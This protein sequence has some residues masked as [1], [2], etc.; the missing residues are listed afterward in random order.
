MKKYILLFIAAAL[1]TGLLAGYVLFRRMLI[2]AP[3]SHRLGQ[4]LHSSAEHPNWLVKAGSRCGTA[5]FQFPT[6]GYIGFLWDDSWQPGQRHQGID[7]FSPE[8]TPVKTPVYAVSDGYLTRQPDW[9]SSVILRIPDDP[10]QPGRQLWTYYT[11]MA[12]PEG[13][14][15]I[16]KDFPPGTA[17]IFVKAGTLLGYQGNFSGDPKN[18]TGLHLHFSIVLDDGT[19]KYRNELKIENTLDPSPYL[20]LNLNAGKTGGEVV[21]C[22]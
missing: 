14:S 6:D 2:T 21:T 8:R 3:R 5:P 19:G 4:W 1:V 22:P 17:D 18:P 11:H 10:L 12:D 9:K 7:I 16:S 13:N 15:F 20:G